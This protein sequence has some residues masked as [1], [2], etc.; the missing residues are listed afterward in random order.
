M[1]LFL[2]VFLIGTP[3]FA[4]AQTKP[5][6]AKE[7]KIGYVDV[8]EVFDECTETQQAT[9]SLKKQIELRQASLQKEEEEITMLQNELREK[10][11]VLSET[12]KDKRKKEIEARIAAL[13]REAAAAK[14]EITAEERD[15][16]NTIV[17]S[18]KKVITG[19]AKADGFGL[20]LEKNSILYAES[21]TDLTDKVVEKLNKK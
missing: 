10:E 1:L 19:I 2:F 3:F 6:T 20:V 14:E 21:G 12:E 16:T 7:F 4:C 18:I 9:L 13:Q 15:L 11:V 5:G 8:K 17:D